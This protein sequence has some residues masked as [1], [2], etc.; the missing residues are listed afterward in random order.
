[1]LRK[2]KG[3]LVGVTTVAATFWGSA[4]FATAPATLADA[5]AVSIPQAV[6]W[7]AM[8]VMLG[9]IGG[10]AAYKFVKGLMSG[11]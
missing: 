1:M 11:R 6:V 8:A 4:A 5:L 2:V 7:T 9:V 3:V 10:I